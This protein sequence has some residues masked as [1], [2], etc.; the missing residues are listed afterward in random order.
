MC[1]AIHKPAGVKIKP[2]VYRNCIEEHPDGVGFAIVKDNHI[3]IQ[4]GLWSLVEFQEKFDELEKDHEALIHF[5]TASPQMEVSDGNCHPFYFDSGDLHTLDD[6][7]PQFEFAIIHNGRLSWRVDDKQKWSDTRTFAYDFEPILRAFPWFLD[8]PM[9]RV[10]FTRTINPYTTDKNKVLIMILDRLKQQHHVIRFGERDGNESCGI[11]FSNTTWKWAK[12]KTTYGTGHN[13]YGYGGYGEWEHGEFMGHRGMGASKVDKH[14]KKEPTISEIIKKALEN[15]FPGFIKPDEKGW[16]YD[17]E[18]HCWCHEVTKEKKDV[19]S[20]RENPKYNRDFFVKALSRESFLT[21][22]TEEGD[23]LEE[24]KRK[25]TLA[26]PPGPTHVND[27]VVN[28]HVA[29]D[30]EKGG[31]KSK[32]EE[33]FEII[34]KGYFAPCF[35]KDTAGVGGYSTRHLNKAQINTMCSEFNRQCSLTNNS[36]RGYSQVDKVLI[37]R[38]AYRTAFPEHGARHWTV[39]DRDIAEQVRTAKLPHAKLS[40]A[41]LATLRFFTH[42]LMTTQESAIEEAQKDAAASQAN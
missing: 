33:K 20:Y 8:Y 26:L 42:N 36:P 12:T 4:K 41:F 3:H 19:L 23:R 9:G 17:F 37:I 10:M 7:T 40:D 11:W 35:D 2:N 31:S 15:N 5:R 27:K 30:K 29:D 18:L 34:E 32:E 21:N 24:E 6:G 25:A 16:F 28:I 39:L 14:E 38:E 22:A 1:I 13:Q